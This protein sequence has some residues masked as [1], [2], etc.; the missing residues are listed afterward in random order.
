MKKNGFTL[1]ELLAVI[2]I[3]AIIALIAVP[4]VLNIIDN[5]KETSN[6]RSID[7]YAKA[8]ENSIIK[9]MAS[10]NGKVKSGIFKTDSKN[11]NKL[12]DSN[13]I[14]S[15]YTIDYKGNK[16]YCDYIEITQ[17]GKIYLSK[18]RVGSVSSDYVMDNET[19]YSVGNIKSGNLTDVSGNDELVLD[20]ML[21]ASFVDYRIYGN[22][23]E[24]E[25]VGDYD[26][27]TGKYKIPITVHGLNNLKPLRKN[28]LLCMCR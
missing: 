24:T 21:N 27:T 19:Y 9:D 20:N 1:I 15:G 18:C 25:S 3:L 23:I 6:K 11:Y 14:D 26:K 10:K 5:S 16:V 12:L 13:D 2:V 4:I 7:M 22:T 8:I 17:D 28:T